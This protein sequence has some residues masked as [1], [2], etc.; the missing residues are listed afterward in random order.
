M[1]NLLKETRTVLMRERG[2]NPPY[3]ADFLN[4]GIYDIR[5]GKI[6]IIRLSIS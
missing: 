5:N 1:I 6:V 3:L 4:G 2:I